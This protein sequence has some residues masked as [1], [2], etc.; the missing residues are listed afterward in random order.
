MTYS[1]RCLLK[2]NPHS[3]TVVEC[4]ENVGGLNRRLGYDDICRALSIRSHMWSHPPRAV[5]RP[6]DRSPRLFVATLRRPCDRTVSAFPSQAPE[7]SVTG[8]RKDQPC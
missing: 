1:F 3:L 5:C 6:L 4:R 2:L 7:L 8:S